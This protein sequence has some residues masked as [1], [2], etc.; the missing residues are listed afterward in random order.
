MEEMIPNRDQGLPVAPQFE[1][2]SFVPPG[3]SGGEPSFGGRSEKC[4]SFGITV[5]AL[6]LVA[7]MVLLFGIIASITG[8]ILS[9]MGLRSSRRKYARIGFWLSVAGLVATL[10]YMLAAY[11]GKINYNYFTTEFWG[12]S[13]SVEPV[14]K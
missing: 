12:G 11:N 14:T 6:S 13:A 9:C 10:W 2:I 1:E 5:G 8:I 3:L 7:W 4:A